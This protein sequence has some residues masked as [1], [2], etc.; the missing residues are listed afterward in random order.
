MEIYHFTVNYFSY[1]TECWRC[2]R[3]H[4]FKFF[5]FYI[6]GS[7]SIC[8]SCHRRRHFHHFLSWLLWITSREQ[9]FSNIIWN[10]FNTHIHITS[11]NHFFCKIT[12]LNQSKLQIASI[13]LIV[14]FKKEANNHIMTGKTKRVVT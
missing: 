9:T 10:I 1:F 3:K 2:P 7:Y 6:F 14:V 4:N 13:I 12:Q 5:Q 8:P 11:K